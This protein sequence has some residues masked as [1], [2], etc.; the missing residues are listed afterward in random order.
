MR[1]SVPPSRGRLLGAIRDCGDRLSS[2]ACRAG[3][4]CKLQASAGDISHAD[5]R[6]SN[7]GVRK[8]KAEDARKK[9][10]ASVLRAVLCDVPTQYRP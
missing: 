3:G 6:V 5:I 8:R 10:Q 4:L 7:N 1:F 9:A 2:F